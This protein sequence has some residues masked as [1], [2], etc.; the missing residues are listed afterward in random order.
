MSLV[1]Y[2][3]LLSHNHSEGVLS[4]IFY[5][6]VPENENPGHLEISNPKNNI[7]ILDR[8][9]LNNIKINKSKIIIKPKKNALI[10]FSS[11]LKHSVKDK[12]TNEDRIS[13]PF[14]MVFKEI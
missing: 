12:L 9:K 10:F 13:I 3:Y 1:Q 11:Y 6:Q 4:G 2:W 7:T 8:D 5:Y 14:D